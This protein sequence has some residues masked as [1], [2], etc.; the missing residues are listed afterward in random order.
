M[1]ARR[2]GIASAFA[3]LLCL[4]PSA[5]HADPVVDLVWKDRPQSVAGGVEF[6]I[7]LYAMSVRPD[8]QDQPVFALDVVL[9]WDPTVIQLIGADDIGP[10]QW[11]SSGFLADPLNYNLDD[12]RAKYTALSRFSL[13]AAAR[14]TPKGL[15]VTSVRFLALSE[16]AL[17]TIVIAP[18]LGPHAQT[19]VFGAEFLGQDVTG[20]LDNTSIA[21]APPYDCDGDGDFDLRELSRL[22]SCFTDSVTGGN[23]GDPR[24]YSVTPEECCGAFDYDD[25]G[26]V[27]GLDL[28]V[29]GGLLNGPL[30]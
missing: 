26:D 27:D 8:G 4:L 3:I 22:Q 2:L 15:L 28:E 21:I 19:K 1:N 7:S 11:L 17:D 9:T 18:S 5:L 24:A 30:R 6:T 29:F 14:A 16:N 10:Y 13:P 12:G 23:L 20:A 25:D